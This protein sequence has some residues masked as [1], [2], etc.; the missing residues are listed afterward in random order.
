MG[1]NFAWLQKWGA[2]GENLTTFCKIG[3]SA[4]VVTIIA[5]FIDSP[6]IMGQSKNGRHRHLMQCPQ[7]GPKRKYSVR[8]VF[9]AYDMKHQ[10]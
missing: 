9:Q 10:S 6:V 2:T 5:N 4:A 1:M 7:R 3:A 8:H